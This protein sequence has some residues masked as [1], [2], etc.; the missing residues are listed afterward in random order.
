[1][2]HKTK[3]LVFN[4][5]YF[6][7]S[8][9]AL[10]M[11]LVGFYKLNLTVP[12]VASGHQSFSS[13]AWLKFCL[14]PA[15]T[16]NKYIGYEVIPASASISIVAKIFCIL[17][18]IAPIAL[19][20]AGIMMQ[21]FSMQKNSWKKINAVFPGAAAMVAIIGIILTNVMVKMGIKKAAGSLGD[22]F[23]TLDSVK[24]MISITP[25]TGLILF[26]I[27]N[28]AAAVLAAVLLPGLNGV[29]DSTGYP[30]G[31]VAD[32]GPA[33]AGPLYHGAG[34]EMPPQPAPQYAGNKRK[35]GMANEEIKISS[36]GRILCLRGMYQGADFTI[37][38]GET[39][40][41]GRDGSIC[42]LV[43][44]DPH[45]SRK[46]CSVSYRASDGMY[47]V[48]NHSQ[49]G[50]QLADGTELAVDCPIQIPGGTAFRINED[51]VFK[52]M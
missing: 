24:N 15:G 29:N 32:P 31:R 42:Q 3:K 1:M 5:I 2:D 18:I 38:P 25:G 10:L 36:R 45:I 16:L 9:L 50:M 19:V 30:Y 46:H 22:M 40:F 20:I 7:V 6:A 49:N 44:N 34:Y 52:T 8:G 35:E 47:T 23:G 12:Y 26:I 51:N 21:I 48:T 13:F 28:I 4:I 39:V 37:E 27:F 33:N 17:V 43:F 11:N 14:D 41:F